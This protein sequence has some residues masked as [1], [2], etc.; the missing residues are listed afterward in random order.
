VT[1]GTVGLVPHWA[2]RDEWEWL[3]AGAGGGVR[4]ERRED[5]VDN[6]RRTDGGFRGRTPPGSGSDSPPR[7]PGACGG[8]SDGPP[9]PRDGSLAPPSEC[10]WP[11]PRGGTIERPAGAPEA[12]LR[13]SSRSRPRARSGPSTG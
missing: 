7:R 8:P 5:P 10:Y 11:M 4:V 12:G 1:V 2:D 6:P 9:A 3:I 13:R